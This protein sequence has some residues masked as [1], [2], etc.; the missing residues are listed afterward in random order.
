MDNPIIVIGSSEEEEGTGRRKREG[1]RGWKLDDEHKIISD[2]S[3]FPNLKA[4]VEAEAFMRIKKKKGK[5]CEEE[6]GR[7]GITTTWSKVDEYKR[8]FHFCSQEIDAATEKEN[9]NPIVLITSSEEDGN[10]RKRKR[11]KC[12]SRMKLKFD[13]YE[14]ISNLSGFPNLKD[15]IEAEAFMRRKEKASRLDNELKMDPH[16][17]TWSEEEE[18]R[19]R[20]KAK[21]RKC[22]RGTRS[23]LDEYEKVSDLSSFPNLKAEN[24][25]NIEASQ[26]NNE[27][28]IDS[29]VILTA[30]NEEEEE[31]NGR[32]EKRRECEGTTRS[33][34]DEYREISD[35]IGFDNFK[36]MIEAEA[37]LWRKK[38]SNK[39]KRSKK[40]RNV[41]FCAQEE[42]TEHAAKQKGQLGKDEAVEIVEVSNAESVQISEI[43][44]PENL[45]IDAAKEKEDR[46]TIKVVE[47]STMVIGAGDMVNSVEVIN[48]CLSSPD[49]TIS[50]V[51]LWRGLEDI[52]PA[53]TV[54]KSIKKKRR[55]KKTKMVTEKDTVEDDAKEE[56]KD[57]V[58]LRMLLRKPRYFDPPSCD[59][60]LCSNYEEENRRVAS[61]KVQK[62][63][64]PCFLCGSFEHIW[65]Y[66]RKDKDRF[67]REGRNHLGNNLSSDICLRCGD[68]GHD[69]FSCRVDYAADDL[70]AIQCY[71]C[72]N[73]GHLSCVNFSETD[74][75]QV[76]CYNCGQSGHMGSECI[77]SRRAPWDTKSSISI[78][79]Y[80]CGKE[81][82]YARRCSTR[83][84]WQR[85]GYLS[86]T[87]ERTHNETR[88]VIEP[89]PCNLS[90]AQGVSDW[91]S[92]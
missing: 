27:I 79:C 41:V 49:A 64:K 8:N 20:T 9:E 74:R 70:K 80:K 1:R 3:G 66:C 4:M 11:K 24:K 48:S 61:C 12:N 89:K 77:K 46:D 59:W 43:D 72:K 62:Q 88:K 52:L 86:S 76:S 15:M 39:K 28:K 38:R 2:L 53:E 87:A 68:L 51:S 30:S 83:L 40:K 56:N 6:G 37:S 23:K 26:L 33:K 92:K 60:D 14:K 29:L 85:P 78:L 57:N 7:N 35:L 75:K 71:V 10:G 58:V 25:R 91:T 54:A 67:V 32:K 13:E 73:F 63:D 17:T 42:V 44:V 50:G 36:A 22:N 31:A 16:M 21:R 18:E 5:S 45:V 47:E 69:M 55:R 90:K 19:N 65:K 81:G 82:H 84:V 34:L